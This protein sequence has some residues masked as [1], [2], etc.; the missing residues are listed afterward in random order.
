MPDELEGEIAK[1]FWYVGDPDAS[2]VFRKDAGEE[3]WN[4]LSKR[5]GKGRA[6]HAPGE[7]EASGTS[8]APA[9]G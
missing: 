6:P 3:M 7:V 9:C 1:G 2:E 5:L 4:D 8:L